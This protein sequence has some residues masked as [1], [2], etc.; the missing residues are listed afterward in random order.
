MKKEDS[1]DFSVGIVL[2]KKI[3]DYVKTGESLAVIHVNDEEK[4]KRASEDLRRIYE[5]SENNIEKPKH[6]LGIVE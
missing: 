4:G 3:G 1:I 2:K 6:I 5:I